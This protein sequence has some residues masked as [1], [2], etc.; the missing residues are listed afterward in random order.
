MIIDFHTHIS[1]QSMISPLVMQ[2][3]AEE[4]DSVLEWNGLA[5]TPEM[6][7]QAMAMRGSFGFDDVINMHIQ[8]K[9]AAGIDKTVSFHTDMALSP[10]QEAAMTDS[11]IDCNKRVADVQKQHPDH[12]I[13]FAG[14]NPKGRGQEGLE[15]FEE[16]VTKWGMKGLQLHPAFGKF[17]PNDPEIYPYYEKAGELGVPVLFHTSPSGHG[18]MMDIEHPKYVDQV[19]AD[20]KDLNIVISHLS[21]PW[22]REILEM[23]KWRSNLY[24]DISYGQIMYLTEPDRFFRFM[25]LL[26]WSSARDRVLFATETPG[27]LSFMMADEAYIEARRSIP[28]S[29]ILPHAQLEDDAIDK[30][31]GGNAARLLGLE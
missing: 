22:M 17:Y 3:L 5:P 25:K 19:A 14:I 7:E 24:V 31:L 12:I 21:D 4:H 28:D 16:A 29:D 13:A 15:L 6:M 9:T 26:L 27:P 1:H 30:L 8:M 11:Y 20:F 2:E 18:W 10:E 23:A